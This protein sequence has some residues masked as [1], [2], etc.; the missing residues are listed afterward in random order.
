MLTP[1]EIDGITLDT[2][3]FGGYDTK[4]VDAFLEPL[5]EDYSTLYKENALLKS[6]MRILVEKLEEYRANESSMKDAMVNAQKNC[7]KMV[8]EAEEK[9]NHIRAG[10]DSK[11]AEEARAAAAAE[12]ARLAQQNQQALEQLVQ[13]QT[14]LNSCIQA[15]EQVKSSSFGGT[16][17]FRAEN[18][19]ADDVA[20]EIAA[21]LRNLMGTTDEPTSRMEPKLSN[22]DS[23]GKFSNLQFGRNYDPVNR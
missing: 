8:R 10:E 6:K 12:A 1:Q 16:T 11:A 9:C 19:V 3:V 22:L 21:N 5:I 20:A 7:D 23:T 4:S 13:V 2:A 14:Q 15:L 17:P 18:D